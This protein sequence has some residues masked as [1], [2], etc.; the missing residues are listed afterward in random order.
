MGEVW[1]PIPAMSQRGH[2]P[3]DTAG[4]GQGSL[5]VE[6]FRRKEEIS[7]HS[8]SQA[9]ENKT[10]TFWLQESSHDLPFSPLAE[11]G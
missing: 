5:M 10:E 2:P 3:C 7:V 11:G 4:K 1:V 6:L 8:L 9:Q